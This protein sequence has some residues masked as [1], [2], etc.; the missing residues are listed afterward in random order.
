VFYHTSVEPVA[1]IAGWFA[2]TTGELWFVS[3]IT[4]IRIKEDS[5]DG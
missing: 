2:F 5:K 3:G 1:L 4:K